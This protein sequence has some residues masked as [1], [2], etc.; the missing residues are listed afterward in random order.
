MYN[1]NLTERLLIGLKTIVDKWGFSH[2]SKITL[3][4]LSENATFLAED[5]CD[6]LII[7]VHRPGYNNRKEIESELVWINEIKEKG[8]VNTP[9]P[10]QTND[11]DYIA[12]IN[13]GDEDRYVVAFEYVEGKKPSVSKDLADWF[14]K[15]GVITARLH[16]H[17]K[18]WDLPEGFQRKDWSLEKCIGPDGHWGDWRNSINLDEE[19]ANTIQKACEIIKKRLDDY[20]K[21]NDRF[22]L[23]HSDL[24]LANLL[25]SDDQMCVIDFDDC[26]FSWFAYDFA[27][28]IS[29]H[30]LDPMVPSLMAAWIKGYRTVS[31]FTY[32]DEKEIPTFILLRRILLTSWL[33]SHNH[34][35]EGKELGAAY[36]DGTVSL[37]KEFVD[38]N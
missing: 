38:N 6:K 26:G 25:I 13:D 34:S 37:A 15:L 2:Y 12:V 16:S 1:D 19:G 4:N 33:A 23:I 14:Y 11:G 35:N 21:S 17:S 24:R 30:E 3:L 20:G 31:D 28:A 8:I 7:R 10:V 9:S 18:G 36:T 22:G 29:F 32:E 27:A 5:D